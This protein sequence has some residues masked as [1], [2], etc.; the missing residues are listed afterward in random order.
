MSYIH[1]QGAMV[2]VTTI[3]P[4]YI[5]IG[6][7]A[8]RCDSL[9]V[10]IKPRRPSSFR[11][12]TSS[13]PT[14]DTSRGGLITA[15]APTKGDTARYEPVVAGLLRPMSSPRVRREAVSRVPYPIDGS[16]RRSWSAMS[17]RDL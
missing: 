7:A 6:K 8:G 12:V 5:V 4:Q 14:I 16:E 10:A 11:P 9:A 3:D 1:H 15:G 2:P 13:P 17:Q